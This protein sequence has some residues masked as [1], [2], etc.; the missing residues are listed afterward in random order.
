MKILAID[1]TKTLRDLLCMTLRSAG[2]DVVEAENG[3]EGLARFQEAKPDV[4]ITDLNMPILNGI[5]FT[6]EC[7]ARPGGEQTPIIILTTEN[8]PDA[9]AEGRRAG[10]TAWMVKPF[11]PT[12]LL[13]LLERFKN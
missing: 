8:G 13:A 5:E 3:E 9:K 2:H 4:V 1:D 6:R 7:R 11:E 12:T 10:A